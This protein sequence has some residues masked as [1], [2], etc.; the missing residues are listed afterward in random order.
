MLFMGYHNHWMHLLVIPVSFLV[1]CFGSS[2]TFMGRRCVLTTV[3][4][5]TLAA[6]TML[7]FPLVVL[8]TIQAGHHYGRSPSLLQHHPQY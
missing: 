3:L 5:S 4:A 7:L 6:R 8:L 2:P 1:I